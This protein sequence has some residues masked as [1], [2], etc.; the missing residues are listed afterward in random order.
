MQSAWG[1]A[2]HAATHDS[3]ATQSGAPAHTSSSGLQVAPTAPDVHASH[4]PSQPPP[5]LVR[6][7]ADPEAPPLPP[8]P[9]GP[10]EAEL[11]LALVD[12]LVSES[13]PHPS[14]AT[15]AQKSATKTAISAGRRRSMEH[16]LGTAGSLAVAV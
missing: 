7:P 13:P 16:L 6:P 5:A 3:I 10:T 11:A 14:A 8:D 12:V 9:L 4:E 1:G 2:A 15:P